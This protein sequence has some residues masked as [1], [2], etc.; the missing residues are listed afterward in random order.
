MDKDG[1]TIYRYQGQ[2]GAYP[3]KEVWLSS[4]TNIDFSNV[5]QMAID[6]SIYALYPNSRILKFSQ[7]SPQSFSVKGV[8]PEIGNIDAVY[9][10]PD[11]Q[12]LYLLDRAGSRVVVTDKK[13]VYKAQYVDPGISQAI[14]LIASESDGKIILL[15]GD[16]LYSLNINQ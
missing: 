4:G 7:G 9:A 8:V 15:I 13:G 10:S 6:G 14:N 16:K 3:N 2:N 12:Y 11:N 5:S 1:N